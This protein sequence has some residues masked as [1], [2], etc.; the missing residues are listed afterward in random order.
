MKISVPL[1]LMG[2]LAGASPI[3]ILTRNELMFVPVLTDRFANTVPA[4]VFTSLRNNGTKFDEP[5]RGFYVT[6][7]LQSSRQKRA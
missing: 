7:V 5:D 3:V 6:L 2:I 1:V 4:G